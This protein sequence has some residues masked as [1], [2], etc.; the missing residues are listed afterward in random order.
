MQALVTQLS[1]GQAG[2][3]EGYLGDD[4]GKGEDGEE[5]AEPTGENGV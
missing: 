3:E 5:A 4:S 1:S 2:G